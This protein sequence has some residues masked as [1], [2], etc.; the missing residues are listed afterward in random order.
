MSAPVRL[1]SY[2]DSGNK[3]NS[4]GFW[5]IDFTTV[6]E[7]QESEDSNL[8]QMVIPMQEAE[9]AM[10]FDFQGSGRKI[11]MSGSRIDGDLNDGS[12]MTNADWI[13]MI[14][15][16]MKG[17]Q[18]LIGPFRLTKVWTPASYM[19]Q[20][21]VTCYIDKFKWRYSVGGVNEITWDLSLLV[22]V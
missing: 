1:K 12:P 14:R 19:P 18:N 6:E 4:S 3:D 9:Q 22:G 16:L 20:E 21:T 7:I 15:N 8:D 13:L 5:Q 2:S 11:S 10:V 17:K